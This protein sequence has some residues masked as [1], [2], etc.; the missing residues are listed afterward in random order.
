MKR[1][2]IKL[3]GKP[4][5]EGGL[6]RAHNVQIIENGEFVP[7]V[8]AFSFNLEVNGIPTMKIEQCPEFIEFDLEGVEVHKEIMHTRIFNECT[9][10]MKSMD[11]DFRLVI[12]KK[13]LSWKTEDPVKLKEYLD[14]CY[15]S[16]NTIMEQYESDKDRKK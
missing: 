7:R 16:L 12:K 4:E 14:T 1:S 5:K 8:Q 9:E 3:V 10:V 2:H 6:V 13:G 11:Y 15:E